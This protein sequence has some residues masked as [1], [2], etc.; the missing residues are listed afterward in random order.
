MKLHA[1]TAA[2]LAL[3]AAPAALAQ[4]APSTW[5][6]GPAF[7]FEFGMGDQDYSTSKIRIEAVR[8]LSAV[9][10]LSNAWFVGSVSMSHPSGKIDLPA[11][12]NPYTFTWSGGGSVEWDANVFELIPAVRL[13]YLLSPTLRLF[14]DGGLGVAYTASRASVSSSLGGA[15]V[16][17][18]AS[19]GFGGVVRLAGGF[20]WSASRSVQV[21]VQPLGLHFRFGDGPGTGYELLLSVTHQL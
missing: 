14:G 5:H 1:S 4:D 11:V 16:S 17:G 8:P 18:V 15:A 6:V 9:S 12:Y 7:G 2:L 20:V 3:L 19:D 10:P 13:D 21:A